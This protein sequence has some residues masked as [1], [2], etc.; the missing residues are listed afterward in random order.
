MEI[1][2]NRMD[3]GFK[4]Y[5]EEFETKTLEIL[6]SGYYI[7][8]K[9]VSAFE[10]EF[11]S[12]LGI[13]Y[14]IGVG[15]G[16][17]ALQIAFHLL[18]IGKGDEVIVPANTYIASV[19]GVTLNDAT[20][21]F[22]EPDKFYNIDAGKIEEKISERTRAILV[23]HLYGQ[24]ANMTEI[25][26]IARK[27]NLRVVEDC[28]QS[29]GASYEGQQTGTFGDFGCFSFYPTKNLG[30]FGD[31]GALVTA[32]AK[33]ADAVRVYRN[34]GSRK[35]YYNEMMGVNSRLD[36][37]Q[38]GLLRVRLAHLDELNAERKRMALYYQEHIINSKFILPEVRTGAEAVW[39]QYIVRVKGRD[40]IQQ[41]L[42][43]KGIGTMVHYPIPPHLS[44]A[45]RY[46]NLQKGSYPITECYADEVLS[47]P[48]Y[49]GMLE[50]ELQYVADVINSFS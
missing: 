44:E 45:L 26:N 37:L 2:C 24:A 32:D 14:C 27:H 19:L 36:E 7:L 47:L 22:V 8:G 35:K 3:R 20:P 12:F 18:G 17:S 6:R 9:E 46:L 25:M 39:H 11:A 30:A 21:I 50:E 5:Q 49:N 41:K 28:A 16:L 4:R 13:P 23:V 33:L 1:A 48:F 29:H 10:S 43:R 15:S 34:Y 31:G 42:Q 38:A 40:E